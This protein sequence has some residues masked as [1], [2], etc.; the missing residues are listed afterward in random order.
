[1]D[2]NKKA[3]FSA[4]GVGA[5]LGAAAYLLARKEAYNFR[6][7]F[8]AIDRTRDAQAVLP[9]GLSRRKTLKILHISDLHLAGHEVKKKISFLDY[10]TSQEYDLIFLTGDIFEHDEAVKYAPHLIARRP[11]LGAYAVLGNHD[12]YHY[13][14]TNKIL[15]RIYKPLRN[16]KDHARDEVPLVEA[17][18]HVG[19]RV[20]RNQVEH[21]EG[22]SLSIVGVDFPGIDPEHMTDLSASIPYGNLKLALLHMPVALDMY[23]KNEIDVVFGGHTHGGQVRIPGIGALITDSELA[24]EHAS[25]LFKRENTHFHISQGL[26]SDPKTNFRV[27][28]PP[29]ATVIEIE[30][31]PVYATASYATSA[32]KT[33]TGITN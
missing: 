24:R 7:D 14:M 1:M 23:V 21:L 28:C 2:V 25:G 18:E 13:N 11:R 9:T 15:G 32:E 5:G 16:P 8:L 29:H 6:I 4:L 10:I 22:E 20:L 27:F 19:Y 26:G 17:L 12:Y 3:F 30:Y 33:K 31:E